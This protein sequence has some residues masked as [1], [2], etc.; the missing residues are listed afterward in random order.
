MFYNLDSLHRICDA[1]YK[2]LRFIHIFLRKITISEN[3]NVLKGQNSLAQGKRS[4]AL[5]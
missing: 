4:V 3:E 2:L 1:F 5:G